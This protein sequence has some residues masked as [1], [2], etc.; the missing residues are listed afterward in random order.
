MYDD[1]SLDF[2]HYVSNVFDTNTGI[3]WH[4]GDDNITKISDLSE[5]VYIIDVHKKKEIIVGLK[6]IFLWFILEQAI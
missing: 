2:G 4:C 6:D 1:D 3:W 5:G